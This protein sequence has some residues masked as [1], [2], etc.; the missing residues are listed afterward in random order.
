LILSEFAGAAHE[1]FAARLVNPFDVQSL[2]STIDD[3]VNRPSNETRT[4]AT[5][6]RRVARNDALHWASTFLAELNRR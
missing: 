3:A 4:M 5:L 2:K 6:A 1:L